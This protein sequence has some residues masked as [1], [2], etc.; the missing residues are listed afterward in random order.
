M[1]SVLIKKENMTNKKT[2][3]SK[4]EKKNKE[5]ETLRKEAHVTMEAETGVRLPQAEECQGLSANT[6][7]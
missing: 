7:S 1:T 3:S 2:P 6:R 5:T 4:K